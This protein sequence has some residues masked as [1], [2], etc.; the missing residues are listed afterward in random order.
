MESDGGTLD[1]DLR[2][3]YGFDDE[4]VILGRPLDAAL[5]SPLNDHF[6]Q[7]PLRMLNKHGLVAGATGTGKTKTLQVF[8]EQLSRA[9]VPVFLADLKGDLTGLAVPGPG[10]EHIDAR[11]SGMDLPW[12]A[13][14]FPVELLSISGRSGT[15]LRVPVS[16][17]GPL[18]LAKVMECSDTQ[19]S[20]LQ[21]IFK[22]ADES[23][24]ALLDLVDL[25]ELLKFLASDDGREVQATY[26]GMSTQT[27]NVL[28]RKTMELQTQGGDTFF[29]EPEFDVEDLVR[30]Q[31][32][33]GVITILN[34]VDVQTKPRIFSTFMMWLLAEIYETSPEVGDPDKPRLVFFFDEAHLLFNG[35]SKTLRSSVELTVRMIRSKGVGV[36]FVTQQPR[37]VPEDVLAQLGNRV[38]HALRAYTPQDQKAL[39]ATAATFPVSAHYDV[40]EALTGLGTGEALVTVLGPK[41]RPTPTVPTRL[42]AP[43]SQMDTV[44]EA[45]VQR[46]IE[47]SPLLARYAQRLDRESAAEILAKRAEEKAAAAV[48]HARSQEEA[49]ALARREKELV[50]EQQRTRRAPTGR[51]ASNRDTATERMVKNAAAS[52]GREVGRSL[53]R[54]ILGNLGR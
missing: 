25:I 39:K 35:A 26:G 41:G 40:Q 4:A 14:S 37:D 44:D 2:A 18:L 12:Q 19:E 22:Y 17:F 10:N 38:Q 47:G 16:S 54:G 28:L 53:I 1:A 15:P 30:T 13:E 33:K 46:L 34:L 20:V 42:V 23:Q 27:I 48:E 31:D 32:G 8:A 5:Q 49:D 43:V 36:F 45:T 51:R 6:V 24:L 50:A 21:V 7:V 11:M 9:G 52:V 3:G 29:G